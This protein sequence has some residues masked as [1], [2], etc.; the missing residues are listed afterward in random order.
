MYWCKFL[1]LFS[2]RRHSEPILMSLAVS[3]S[4]TIEEPIRLLRC[5]GGLCLHYGDWHLFK[6][7]FIMLLL[8]YRI[9]WLFWTVLIA[10]CINATQSCPFLVYFCLGSFEVTGD[11]PLTHQSS[12]GVVICNDCFIFSWAR[13]FVVITGKAWPLLDCCHDVLWYTL[14]NEALS[15]GEKNMRN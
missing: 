15:L 12:N 8:F 3:L 6:S 10:G 4:V 11:C 1:V 13:L 9:Q 5:E 2:A 7:L 14:L